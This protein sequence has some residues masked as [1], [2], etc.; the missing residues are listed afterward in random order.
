MPI[1]T[2]TKRKTKKPVKGRGLYQTAINKILKPDPPLGKNE[3]HPIMKVNGKYT[4][5]NYL[6]PGSDVRGKMKKGIRG[7]SDIDNIAF[8][9]DLAYSVA[10]NKG[11]IRRADEHMLKRVAAVEKRKSDSKHNI[12]LAK[13]IKGKIALEKIGVPQ[14]AFTETGDPDATPEEME[15]MR[16]KMEELTTEGFG[17]KKKTTS[18]NPWMKHVAAYRK[19]H[20]EMTYKDC[21]R[22]CAKTYKK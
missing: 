10:K 17:K 7:K 18:T 12:R 5:G 21:L 19:K 14:S 13:L 8:R 4:T 6:G 20:P 3:R 9:H 11:D 22:N 1:K 16:Q 15:E 2:N